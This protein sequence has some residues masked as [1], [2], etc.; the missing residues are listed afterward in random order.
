M[1]THGLVFA[2]TPLPLAVLVAL[3]GSDIDD[4][5]QAR[6]LTSRFQHMKTAHHVGGIGFHRLTIGQPHQWL[7]SHMNEQI[8]VETGHAASYRLQIS[9]ITN[10]G[11]HASL[12]SSFVEQRWCCGR[13]KCE[14]LNLG[15]HA[16]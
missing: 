4:G 5:P 7:G 2:I 10:L 9:N 8:R 6:A 13:S 11:L 12:N 3:V 14:T 15:A 16:L 1:S